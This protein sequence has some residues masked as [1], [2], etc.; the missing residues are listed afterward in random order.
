MRT[1][2]IMAFDTVMLSVVNK[3]TMLSVNM[4]SVASPTNKH[5]FKNRSKVGDYNT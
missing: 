4:L 5:L 3:P 2:S 1:F